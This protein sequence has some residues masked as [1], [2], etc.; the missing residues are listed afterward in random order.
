MINS[1]GTDIN[2]EE[3]VL[4]Y[5]PVFGESEIL[6]Y[7]E[8]ALPG[9]FILVNR[10][11]ANSA[12]MIYDSTAIPDLRSYNYKLHVINECGDTSLP[13]RTHGTIYLEAY[14]GG[15]TRNLF[16]N[17]YQG[18]EV[19]TFEI[20]RGT[21]QLNMTPLN[22]V[23][24]HINN[25]SDTNP[26]EGTVHYRIKGI[27]EEN[28]QIESGTKHTSLSNIASLIG[29]NTDY[30]N[31]SDRLSIAPNPVSAVSKIGFP[32]SA[33]AEYILSLYELTGRLVYRSVAITESSF[34][35]NR[36]GI[37]SGL[38]LLELS[39]PETFRARIVID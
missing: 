39:G 9:S 19:E 10:K 8:S 28:S 12:G 38:Y 34:E 33:N 27:L 1:V 2:S 31:Q 26:P 3:V 23:P 18:A 5:E 13:S 11:P 25:F 21:T 6:L 37:Q 4:S 22:W 35:F 20:L 36:K 32:N 24:G 16:W 14:A 15:H 29:V 7:K 30:Y 17:L